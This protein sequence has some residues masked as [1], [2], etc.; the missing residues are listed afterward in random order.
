MFTVFSRF[1]SPPGASFFVLHALLLCIG[2]RAYCRLQGTSFPER[3]LLCGSVFHRS[4]SFCL[5]SFLCHLIF[6]SIS[7]GTTALAS[8]CSVTF[9]FF[10]QF[11]LLSLFWGFYQVGLSSLFS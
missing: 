2:N 6:S 9:D 4:Q 8:V 1:P 3:N 10:L 7:F 5:T 11:F